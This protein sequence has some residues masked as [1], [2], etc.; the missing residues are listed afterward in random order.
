MPA[1]PGTLMKNVDLIYFNAGGGHRAAALALQEAIR[2]QQR[3]WNVR[4]VNLTEVIDPGHRFKRLTGLAPEDLYNRRLSRGWTFGM[5]QELKVLQG[6]IR[7]SHRPLVDR[8]K[9]HWLATAPD[10]VV[11]LVPNFNRALYESARDALPG[12]PYATVM[13]DM[14]D[15]PPNFW[16]EPGQD[17]HIVCGTQRAL[18]Q[19]RAA[20]YADH[21]LSLTSGM[22]LRPAFYD[23]RPLDRA[24][25]RLVLGLDPALPTGVVMFGGH[26]SMQMARIARDLHDTQLILLCGHNDALAG[27]LLAQRPAVAH[28]VVGFTQD[29]GRLMRLGDFFI[30]KPGPGSLSEAVHMGLP[31]ITVDNRWTMPQERYNAQWVR[32]RGLGLVL[33]SARELPGG[34][35]RMLA[36]LPRFQDQVRRI[37]NRAVF[38]VVE[39]ISDLLG[40]ASCRAAWAASR[41]EAGAL[42]LAA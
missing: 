19:A 41:A 7:W 36:E 31:V 1:I 15:H 18:E 30:G 20:G 26:G 3:P 22:I 11:S 37:D 10:L 6:A 12:T 38:E 42:H 13:T 17:Q 8:L 5:A 23:S 34:V 40:S 14:A 28:A 2:R 16:I 24:R 21:R 39:I 35:R 25:E 27:K 4:L 9:R 33:P 32:E 29:V